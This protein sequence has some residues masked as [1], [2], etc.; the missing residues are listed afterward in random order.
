MR[1]GRAG[2]RDGTWED[3]GVRPVDGTLQQ[4]VLNDILFLL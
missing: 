3:A 1:L 2:S 4:V